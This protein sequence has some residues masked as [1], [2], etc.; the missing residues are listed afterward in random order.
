MS[1]TMHLV[2]YMKTGPTALHSGGWRHPEAT[3]GDVFDPRRYEQAA[4]LFESAKLDGCFFADAFG[5]PD[6]YQGPELFAESGGQNSYLDP[7]TVLPLMARVTR[8][9]GLGVTVSTSFHSAYHL[10]RSLASVDMLSGGRVAWNLVTST[11]TFEAANAGI[12]L[13]PHDERYDRADEVVEACMALWRT[14]D[15][16]PFVLD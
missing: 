1:E 8:H 16:D 4:Q 11:T 6:T 13:P 14:W 12:E 7:L 15:D 10:A 5:F 3:P 9:L 2:A